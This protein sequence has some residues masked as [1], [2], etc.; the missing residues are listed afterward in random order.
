MCL[1]IFCLKKMNC[2]EYD[3]KN[4]LDIFLCLETTV[5]KKFLNCNF[6]LIENELFKDFLKKMPK[7][8]STTLE[9]N[10]GKLILIGQAHTFALK[11][12][13]LFLLKVEFFFQLK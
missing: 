3:K 12:A 2:L 9:T 1:E 11:L 4:Q 7:F 5:C 10:L 8:H 6:F 13:H